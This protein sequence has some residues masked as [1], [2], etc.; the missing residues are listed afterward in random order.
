VAA[1]TY[2]TGGAAA[3]TAYETGCEGARLGTS[4]AEQAAYTAQQ[5]ALDAKRGYE[6]VS[7]S[8]PV[9]DI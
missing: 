3:N 4:A 8:H 9:S 5:A 2:D 6:L 7:T 1:K